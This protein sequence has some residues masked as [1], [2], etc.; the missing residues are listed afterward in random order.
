MEQRV[1]VEAE[2]LPD[3]L[4]VL[5]DLGRACVLLGRHVAGLFEERHVHEARCV[6]L[7]ARV[8]VPVPRAPEVA[9]LLDDADVVDAGVLESG[10]GD[11]PGEAAAD[12][13]HRHVVGLGGPL[14]PRRVRIVEIVGQLVLQLQ[15]LRV[16][17]RPQALGPLLR[18]TLLQRVFVHRG[19]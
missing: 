8:P 10:A 15:I 1:V 16:S 6:A 5:E 9:A 4:A 18:V 3:A 13:R 7:C 11:Q 17:V 14:G 12:E 19:H 2:L